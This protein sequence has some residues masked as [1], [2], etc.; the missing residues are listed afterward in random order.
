MVISIKVLQKINNLMEKEDLHK[1]VEIFIKD[2]SK[3]EKLM[4]MEYSFKS[5]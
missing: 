5:N 4:V 2:N 1:H 3:M